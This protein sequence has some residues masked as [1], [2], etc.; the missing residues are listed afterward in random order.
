MYF[1]KVNEASAN[2]VQAVS[3]TNEEQQPTSSTSSRDVEQKVVA[4]P[5]KK[6]VIYPVLKIEAEE[7][8]KVAT[9]S[10]AV[11]ADAHCPSTPPSRLPLAHG[12]NFTSHSCAITLVITNMSPFIML[13]MLSEKN[14]IKIHV[15]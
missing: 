1:I 2:K 6:M 3:A 13:M 12:I 8:L 5:S 7:A 9:Q 10:V 15:S 14:A 4:N 11:I